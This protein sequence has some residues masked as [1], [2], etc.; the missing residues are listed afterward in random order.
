MQPTMNATLTAVGTDL[1]VPATEGSIEHA[2]TADSRIGQHSVLSLLA[3][4]KEYIDQNVI[5]PILVSNDIS[6][7]FADKRKEYK[8]WRNAWVSAVAEEVRNKDMDISGVLALEDAQD[9]HLKKHF[10]GSQD[11]LGESSVRALV[12][13]VNLKK[14]VR[15]STMPHSEGW[16]EES[17][18]QI[19]HLFASSEFCMIGVLHHLA[20]GIGL[21]EN[22]RTLADWS[23]IYASE[24]YDE[25][26]Y[27]GP[28]AAG[29]ERE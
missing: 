2:G 5:L 16:S 1:Y 27:F 12:G 21:K 28:D 8:D 24:A 7:T 26:G 23:F 17:W 3:R 20:T 14:I 22:V 29:I 19:A 9:E 6:A 18:R 13:A 11:K 4:K 15:H 10:N 25:A